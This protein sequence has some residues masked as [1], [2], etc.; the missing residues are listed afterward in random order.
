MVRPSLILGMGVSYVLGAK[1]GRQRYEQIQRMWRR[2]SDSPAFQDAADKVKGAAAFGLERARDKAAEGISLAVNN[3]LGLNA[4]ESSGSNSSS[5]SRSNSSASKS[6]SGPGARSM[7]LSGS[8]SKS[9]GSKAKS[10]RS[11]P[12]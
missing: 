12:K 4:S 8:T 11:K 1:A 3:A 10:T 6:T 2:A 7:R 9:T 5:G